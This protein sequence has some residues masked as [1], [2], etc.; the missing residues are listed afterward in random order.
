[1]DP[2]TQFVHGLNN[3]CSKYTDLMKSVEEGGRFYTDLETKFLLPLS[4]NVDD[5]CMARQQEAQINLEGL[6]GV[7]FFLFFFFI[8][9]FSFHF[10]NVI[11]KLF[12][13]IQK[14]FLFIVSPTSRLSNFSTPKMIE[15]RDFNSS[16]G[17]RLIFFFLF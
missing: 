14:Q 16:I 4:Q 10:N 7:N 12:Y 11:N 8:L 2:R 13:R 9:S 5:Y 15:N 3:T 17:G 1:M 6:G